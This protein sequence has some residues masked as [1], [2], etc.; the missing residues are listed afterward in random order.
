MARSP[1][2]RLRRR[3]MLAI[4]A[5]VAAALTTVVRPTPAS[6]APKPECLADLLGGS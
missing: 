5:L 4:P 3:G 6:A 2:I 1:S